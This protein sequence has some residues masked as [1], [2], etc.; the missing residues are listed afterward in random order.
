[1][2]RWIALSAFVMGCS[3]SSVEEADTFESWGETPSEAWLDEY[4]ELPQAPVPGTLVI[5]GPDRLE[6]GTDN[7]LTVTGAEV[8]ADVR[9][10]AGK[11]EEGYFCPEDVPS[12]LSVTLPGCI[13]I[14][15]R[16]PGYPLTRAVVVGVEAADDDGTATFSL[17]IPDSDRARA[18]M[19]AGIHFQAI[20]MG[21]TGAVSDATDYQLCDDSDGDPATDCPIDY[22]VEQPLFISE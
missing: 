9:L 22:G 13:D 4:A 15:L 5:S 7:T 2:V 16:S 10:I 17:S 21:G 19:E 11:F 6:I 20:Q 12:S 14:A 8:G 18:V 1:M 3:T